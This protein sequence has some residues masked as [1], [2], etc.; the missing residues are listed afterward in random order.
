[1]GSSELLTHDEARK[2]VETYIE[3]GGD[4]IYSTQEILNS[5]T[6]PR[7]NGY[8]V[9]PGKVSDCIFGGHGD[10]LD[11]KTG[12]DVE[13]ANPSLETHKGIAL[14]AMV[15]TQRI[16]THDINRGDIPFKD[17]ILAANHNFMRKMLAPALGS[18]QFEID[19]LEESSIVIAAE[20]LTQ[21]RL[22]NVI[23]NYMATST[24]DTNMGKQYLEK[25]VRYFGGHHLPE[26][27][28]ANCKLP[29]IMDTPSTKSDEHDETVDP[30]F[31]FDNE[32]CSPHQY[33]QIRNSGIFAFGMVARFLEER[34]IIAVDTK[35]EHGIN[36]W[37][38]IVVQDEIWN[39]DSSRFWLLD[40]YN[41]QLE[42]LK[43]GEIEKLDPKSYSK[44]FA[45]G[46][47]QGDKGYTD[48]Q[49]V[50]I[51]VRYIE[52]I[53]HLLSKRFEPDMR[54]GEERVIYGLERLVERLVA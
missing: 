22:E 30:Q 11:K 40:D 8:Q 13:F 29:Y 1:M 10:Y 45:R 17:Q 35:T 2:L 26:G 51:A 41:E 25:G 16:S 14:R 48:E 21:I 52:G 15:R 23:R 39:M 54:S 20:N 53:Q 6:I 31:L 28:T 37:G 7:L 27:L 12:K 50:Q 49:R 19:G 46:F 4:K 38:R 18:S 36:S 5:G 3:K 34:G 32:I 42:K 9:R 43:I 24:T 44:E 33:T 47:S